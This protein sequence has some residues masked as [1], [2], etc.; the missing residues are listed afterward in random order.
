[1]AILTTLAAMLLYGLLH[2][3]LAGQRVKTTFCQRY[4]KHAYH[5]LYRFLYNA[6]AAALFA[7]IILLVIF[8]PGGL[9][10]SISPDWELPLLIIQAVGIAGVLAALLQ[11]DLLRFAGLRQLAAY[12]TDRPLPLP[13]EAMQQRGMYGYMRHPLYFFSLLVIWPV[14]TMTESYF[15]FCIGATGYFLI[16]SRY[17]ER[18]LVA[19]FGQEYITY[20]RSVPWLVPFLRPRNKS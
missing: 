18:R 6:L 2:S 8:N 16:G 13:E 12:L 15:G 1:M 20:R 19:A 9:I 10:W 11:I 17:E 14:T 3:I 5:G 7:P 4:G